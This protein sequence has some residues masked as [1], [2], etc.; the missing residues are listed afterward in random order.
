VGFLGVLGLL[1]QQLGN[2]VSGE[3][4]DRANH[5]VFESF[6]IDLAKIGQPPRLGELGNDSISQLVE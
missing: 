3:L 6:Q 1:A 2:N 4:V 5:F